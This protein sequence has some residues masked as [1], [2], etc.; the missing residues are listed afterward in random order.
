MSRD[1]VKLGWAD[2]LFASA[3]IVLAFALAMIVAKAIDPD[4]SG[5]FPMIGGR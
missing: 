3:T 1:N 2:A 5:A 4:S